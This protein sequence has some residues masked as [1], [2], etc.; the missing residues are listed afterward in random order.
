MYLR[1]SFVF[2]EISS[3]EQD[4]QDRTLEAVTPYRNGLKLKAKEKTS[5]FRGLGLTYLSLCQDDDKASSKIVSVSYA[6]L[7]SLLPSP[8]PGNAACPLVLTSG[9]YEYAEIHSE[10][11]FTFFFRSQDFHLGAPWLACSK[12]SYISAVVWETVLARRFSVCCART[13]THSRTQSTDKAHTA[14]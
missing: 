4:V 3:S 11:S 8:C 13:Q 14:L 2:E 10:A 1:V 6:S 7:L 5:H 9:S 12:R